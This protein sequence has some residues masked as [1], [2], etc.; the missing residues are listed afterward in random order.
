MK[1]NTSPTERHSLSEPQELSE[2]VDIVEQD[3]HTLVAL[4]MDAERQTDHHQR[5]IE[6]VTANLGRPRF[7]YLILVCVGTW[8]TLN[9]I[10]SLFHLP[11]FD[12]PPFYWLQG[13]IGLSA[14]LM[15]TVVLITQ[16]RQGRLAEQRRHLDLEISLLAERK[17][18]KLIALVEE[19]RHD[20][21]IVEDRHDPV[22]NA[23]KETANPGDVLTTFNKVWRHANND[24]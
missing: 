23:M 8:T 3:I 9:L 4:R 24:E 21:P 10:C 16:N 12:P 5:M 18:S 7:F 6:K 17:V 19:L 1:N 22:A 14:L 15:T 20:L 2:L 13:L 11:T